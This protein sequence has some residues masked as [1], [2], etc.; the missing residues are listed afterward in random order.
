M[1][2]VDGNGDARDAVAGQ[3]ESGNIAW[4]I[5]GLFVTDDGAVGV[6][7]EDYTGE[8]F[9]CCGLELV[10]PNNEGLQE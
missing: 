2:E 10:P 1:G 4:V 8:R 7:D 9:A 5:C 3:D 6:T